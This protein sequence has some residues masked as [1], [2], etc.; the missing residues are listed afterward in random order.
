MVVTSVMSGQDL[1]L[2]SFDNTEIQFS[3][4]SSSFN[5]STLLDTPGLHST[6]L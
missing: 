5:I 3:L 1:L 2:L 4:V 6:Q